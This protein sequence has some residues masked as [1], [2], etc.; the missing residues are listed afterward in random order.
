VVRT[1]PAN[2]APRAMPSPPPPA[3]SKDNIRDQGTDPA[4]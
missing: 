4:R 2:P 3:N 1:A